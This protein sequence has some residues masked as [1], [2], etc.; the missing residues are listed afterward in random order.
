MPLFSVGILDAQQ[1]ALG[2]RD[3][4]FYQQDVAVSVDRV[5]LVVEHGDLVATHCFEDSARHLAVPSGPSVAVGLGHAVTCRLA[6]KAPSLHEVEDCV[7]YYSELI[8]S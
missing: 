8:L 3:C 2:A 6:L 5:Q 4:T 7:R 1:A